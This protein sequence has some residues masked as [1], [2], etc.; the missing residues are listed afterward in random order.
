MTPHYHHSRRRVARLAA[1]L[2]AVCLGAAILA[3]R[4]RSI[5]RELRVPLAPRVGQL[6]YNRVLA[7][8]IH[9]Y[10][11]THGRPAYFLDS[12][13][14]HLDSAARVEFQRLRTDLWGEPVEYVWSWCDF[15]LGSE[16]GAQT[17]IMEWYP[18]PSG[19]GRSENCW[20]AR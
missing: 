14:V 8:R 11:R 18:W 16:G 9:A 6:M 17:V 1:G 2:S 19:V 5:E 7:A 10:A 13:E 3:L 12:V 20:A 4:I 15:M